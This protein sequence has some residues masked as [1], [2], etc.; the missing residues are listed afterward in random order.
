MV[1]NSF[2]P[3]ASKEAAIFLLLP[4]ATEGGKLINNS[5]IMAL[6][7]SLSEAVL[8]KVYTSLIYHVILFALFAL[9]CC[10][11][12]KVPFLINLEHLGAS[13]SFLSNLKARNI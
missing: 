5:E 11:E 9:N 6:V 13:D 10:I 1:L 12:E 4:A 3:A 7:F 2:V 8:A